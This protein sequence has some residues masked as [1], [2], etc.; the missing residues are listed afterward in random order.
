MIASL[1]Q[2]GSITRDAAGSSG[3]V[4]GGFALRA[5]DEARAVP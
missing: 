2:S 1:Y 4:I 3:F 5:P